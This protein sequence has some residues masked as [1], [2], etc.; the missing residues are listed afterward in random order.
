[1]CTQ[2]KIRA[3]DAV[4][5]PDLIKQTE[6][7]KKTMKAAAT[8]VVNLIDETIC[9]A[10]NKLP[11][12][13][14]AFPGDRLCQ[15]RLMILP[16]L[17]EKPEVCKELQELSEKIKVGLGKEIATLEISPDVNYLMNCRLLKIT[18]TVKSIE[19]SGILLSKT[20]HRQLASL[21]NELTGKACEKI[22]QHACTR[23]SKETMERL[24]EYGRRM[25]VTELHQRMLDHVVVFSP[26]N[27]PPR[28]FGCQ[29]FTVHLALHCL[30]QRKN[31][32]AIK[33]IVP[34]GPSRLIFF[35]AQ[36]ND[37]EFQEAPQLEK[38]SY[39]AIFQA[40][41]PSEKAL[42]AKVK[43][44]GFVELILRYSA[45]ETPFEHTSSLSDVKDLEARTL[46]EEYRKK[47][48]ESGCDEKLI[49]IHHLY[50][51]TIQ[52]EVK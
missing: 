48:A 23:I 43:E 26:P 27:F 51:S 34:E 40:V 37:F 3:L 21:S 42:V 41:V 8:F 28:S 7:N 47:A 14:D 19:P 17:F 38:T 18:R 9:H 6:M 2:V 5:P 15:A 24:Q 11:H 30:S 22:T 20:D 45:Q 13:L 32:L 31:P 36:E 4:L 46:I 35:K 25:R 12:G 10:A 39:V 1:M 29:F 49:R 33:T 16:E 50:S 52:E 44:I